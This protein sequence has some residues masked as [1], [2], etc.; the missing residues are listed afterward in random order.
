VQ[1]YARLL[2]L[3][4]LVF[5]FSA[6]LVAGLAAHFSLAVTM[7][8]LVALSVAILLLGVPHGAL[9]PIF[10]Q[11][12]F[13]LK[14]VGAWV[15]FV[16]AYLGLAGSVVGIWLVAPAVWLVL[17]LL[18]SVWHF[19][20]DLVPASGWLARLSYGSSILVLPALKFSSELTLLFSHLLNPTQSAII[21]AVLQA[22]AIPVLILVLMSA[23][24]VVRTDRVTA[25]EIVSVGILM[26]FATPLLAFTVY[27]CLMHGLRHILRTLQLAAAPT[28][29]HLA[30][31][32]ALPM[33]G[34]LILVVLGLVFVE[35]Q[36]LE[37][38]LMQ[39]VFVGLAALTVPHMCLVQGFNFRD[40]P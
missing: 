7:P 31:V 37:Q 1:P 10:A 13:K 17:F 9:D 5:G 3:Q 21:V 8:L 40:I 4:G 35:A 28:L 22:L 20:N 12:T 11:R 6:L 26:I 39:L 27:F 30:R 2:R 19:S 18:I 25:L 16:I 32:M 29:T 38:G 36:A 33:L 15:V 23:A 34:T 24:W 14:G